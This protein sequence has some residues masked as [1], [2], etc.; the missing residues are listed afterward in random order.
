MTKEKYFTY[1]ELM[2]F[3]AEHYDEG[4]YAVV[5]F[6]DKSDFEGDE[7]YQTMTP[8]KALAYFA[9][10]KSIDDEYIAAARYFSGE[11]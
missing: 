5:E 10:S 6:L 9:T 3:G 4:G 2:E 11:Y 7:F 8:E 1:E